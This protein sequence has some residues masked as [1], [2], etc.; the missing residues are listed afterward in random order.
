MPVVPNHSFKH[1]GD[2]NTTPR[3]GHPSML[4]NISHT[5]IV[6][7]TLPCMKRDVGRQAVAAMFAA[8]GTTTVDATVFMSAA[9]AM[10]AAFKVTLTSI[11]SSS[12]RMYTTFGTSANAMLP[13]IAPK[14]T[15]APRHDASAHPFV[16]PLAGM[17]V[18]DFKD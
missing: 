18:L 16:H 6:V 15:H 10:I 1:S 5:M 4:K 17:A 3:I 13:T 7:R 11:V 14:A 9:P 12:T 2:K 8:A